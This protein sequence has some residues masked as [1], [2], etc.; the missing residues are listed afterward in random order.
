MY[1]TIYPKI[2]RK[3]IIINVLSINTKYKKL[4]LISFYNITIFSIQY[5]LQYI[6]K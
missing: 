4:I 5:M 2:T 3:I 6:S 1:I